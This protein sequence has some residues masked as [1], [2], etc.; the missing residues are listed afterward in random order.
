ME[1]QFKCPKCAKEIST[2]YH[3]CPYCGESITKLSKEVG[4]R[5]DALAQ[6]KLLAYLIDNV[7]DEKTLNLLEN[8]TNKCKDSLK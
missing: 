6:L 4:R 3:F 8:L 1:N 5:Q 7:Q 2:E